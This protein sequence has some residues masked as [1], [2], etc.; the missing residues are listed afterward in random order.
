MHST[1]HNEILHKSRQV[2]CRGARKIYLCSVEYILNESTSNFDQILNF[3]KIS[4]MCVCV[5]WGSVPVYI[6][7]P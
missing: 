5:W 3:I 4:L 6:S 7:I 1:K 2:H